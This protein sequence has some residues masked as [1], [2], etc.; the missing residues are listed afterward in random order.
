MPVTDIE[1]ELIAATSTKKKVGE[2]R[3]AYLT[4]VKDAVL[5]LGDDEW[6][7]LSTPSQVWTNAAVTTSDKGESISDFSDIV[8]PDGKGLKKAVKTKKDAAAKKAVKPTSMRRSIK[9]MLAKNPALTVDELAAKLKQVGHTP[10]PLAIHA[11]RWDTRDTFKV[12][13]ECGM[14][15]IDL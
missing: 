11:I 10:T 7:S 1:T 9:F 6:E 5:G 8:V 14:L 2:K 4:R 12:L 15:K 3:Q 13:K